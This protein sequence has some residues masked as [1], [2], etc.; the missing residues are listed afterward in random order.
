M[1]ELARR[2]ATGV[3]FVL[4]MITGI[5]AGRWGYSLLFTAVTGLSLWEFLYLVL[6]RKSRRD[7]IR[8]ALGLLLG[9]VPFAHSLVLQLNIINDPIDFVIITSILY[10]PLVFGA[11]VYELFMASEKPFVN[12]AFLML[13]VFYIGIPFGLLNF[14]AIHQGEYLPN[15]VMGLLLLIWAN[16]SGAY[17]VGSRLGKHLLL[18]R[19]SPKKTW[20]GT[21]GG[22]V[23]TLLTAVILHL[24]FLELRLIDWLVLAGI[25]AVFGSIGDLVESMLKR[26]L[27]VK[28]SG[29]I[30]PGHGGMLDRFDGLIFSLPYATAYLL[31][32]R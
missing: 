30:L 3:I 11:F 12:L 13:G 10:S 15:I 25:I 31:W 2:T 20:E 29:K 27:A 18:P 23:F 9:I 24:Y 32:I 8:K 17:L 28:D 22:L 1:Q 7:R 6:D 5:Y 16:D 26:S 14:V 19:I 4:V 21:L